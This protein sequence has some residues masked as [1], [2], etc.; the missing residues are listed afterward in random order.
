MA[1]CMESGLADAAPYR[2]HSRERAGTG[3]LSR[4]APDKLQRLRPDWVEI[5]TDG[6]EPLGYLYHPG[7]II[8]S[9]E[10]AKFLT[11]DEVVHWSPIPDPT[12]AF[13]GMSWVTPVVRE[14]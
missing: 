4:P 11:V 1:F 2:S 10:S 9:R 12:A 8:A 6:S 7:G 14:V 13:R 5:L 3:Y